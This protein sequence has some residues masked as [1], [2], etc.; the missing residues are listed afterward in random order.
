ML[1]STSEWAPI[2]TPF[3]FHEEYHPN[4]HDYLKNHYI[5]MYAQP[6]Y[7]NLIERIKQ[8]IPVVPI[9]NE[10]NSNMYADTIVC[11]QHGLIFG[12]HSDVNPV[13]ATYALNACICLL[14]YVPKY[15]VGSLAHIDGLPGYSKESS[16]EDGIKIDFSPIELNLRLMIAALNKIIEEGNPDS[17]IILDI[18][19]YLIGGIY[20]LSEVMIHDILQCISQI[21][22]SGKINFN[23]KGR[24]LLGP[25]NQTRNICLDTRTGKITY[26][27]YISN[28]EF[29]KDHLNEKGIPMNILKAPRKSEAILDITYFPLVFK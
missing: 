3:S 12:C 22:D 19:F 29:Y 10:T 17:D 27:D 28:L 23:F 6:K 16:I 11:D 8:N 15:K 7:K 20:E 1:Q 4:C 25:I 9:C 24:N 2:D 13:L 21:N 18:D 14:L 5:E 26:F